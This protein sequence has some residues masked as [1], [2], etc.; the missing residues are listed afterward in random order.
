MP[1]IISSTSLRNEY[2]DVSDS[3]ASPAAALGVI[4]EV[5]RLVG[6]LEELPQAHASVRDE[7]L[8]LAGYRWAP[9]G[10]YMAFFTIDEDAA[11]V[12]IERILHGSRNWR[13]I[14]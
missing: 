7:M 13:E 3:L 5:E 1:K 11:T 14:V 2:N 6:S 4:D 12:N 9:I 10:S 8:A